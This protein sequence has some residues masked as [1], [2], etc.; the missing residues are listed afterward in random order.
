MRTIN[1]ETGGS[2]SRLAYLR[3]DLQL[4]WLIVQMFFA[5]FVVGRR[6]RTKYREMEAQGQVYWVDEELDQ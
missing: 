4:L 5:Y 2:H 6:I 1:E 3:R